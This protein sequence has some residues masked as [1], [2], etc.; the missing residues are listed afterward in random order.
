M[1]KHIEAVIQEFWSGDPAYAG[2]NII[3]FVEEIIK[4]RKEYAELSKSYESL[5]FIGGSAK[6]KQLRKE[7]ER[8]KSERE[9][10]KNI[11]NSDF[12]EVHKPIMIIDL[13]KACPMC[14]S[15]LA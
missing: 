5:I 12:S 13:L 6:D 2:G 8:Y 1:N 15:P 10:I 9:Q 4:L 3:A 7:N 14:I 11:L